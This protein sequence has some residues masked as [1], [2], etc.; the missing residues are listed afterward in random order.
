MNEKEEPIFKNDLTDEEQKKLDIMFEK[1]K[2]AEKKLQRN[3]DIIDGIATIIEI[4]AN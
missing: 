2:E 4:I 1:E 3:I